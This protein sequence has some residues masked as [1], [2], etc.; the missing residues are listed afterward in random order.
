MKSFFALLVVCLFA[1]CCH[2]NGIKANMVGQVTTIMPPTQ[3]FGPVVKMAIPS[4]TE[5][6]GPRIAVID[7]D[8]VLLNTD[9]TG[10][11]S[12][13]ENPVGLFREKLDAVASDPC[14]RAVVLRINSP[15]GAV[16]ASDIMWRDLL[17]F[18]QRTGLPVVAC[19][20]D[21]GAGGAYYL[22]TAADRI[23]AHPTT[24]TGGV[25]VILNLYNLHETMS[26]F[27]VIGV[28][29]K[30]GENIDLGSPVQ[31][32]TEESRQLLQNMADE[33]SARFRKIVQDS[34]P[35]L[36]PAALIELDGRVF[37]ASHALKQGF[38]DEIG[39]LD[40]A[41]QR[42]RELSGAM[43]A[44]MV[45]FHRNNDRA[46]S[47]Y[48][49]T[50]NVPLQGSMLPVSIPGLDRSRLPTFLYLWQPDPALEKWGGH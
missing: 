25:G 49:V 1:G 16:T 50:P 38:I 30:S 2:G 8:G 21:V 43:D 19:M 3:I 32:M 5:A 6:D 23:V 9:M 7:V 17:A 31:A 37:T 44:R 33:F 36:Q 14:I 10:M 11:S 20:L 34:R 40:D 41:V 12:L 4:T 42:A 46:R 18:K 26:Q 39:Y 27:N 15:G 35:R 28:P 47:Q 45:M 24:V 48:A 29:V 13:G 22:A